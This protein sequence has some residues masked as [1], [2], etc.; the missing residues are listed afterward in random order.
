VGSY[1]KGRSPYG[2]Y[3]VAGNVWDWTEDWY[4]PYPGNQEP[5]DNYGERYKVARGGGFNKCTF[6]G[7]GSHAPTFNRA[8]FN[9]ASRMETFGFRCARSAGP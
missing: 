6:Y 7:C 1:P 4:K 3:D 8:F 9:P 2:L 5:D